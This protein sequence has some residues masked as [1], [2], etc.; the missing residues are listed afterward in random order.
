MLADSSRSLISA[1]SRPWATT[2][3]ACAPTGTFAYLKGYI[4][5]TAAKINFK[6]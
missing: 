1:I 2:W 4:Y 6:T 3:V 5:C